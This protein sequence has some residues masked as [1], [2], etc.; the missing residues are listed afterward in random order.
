MNTHFLK[1]KDRNVKQFLLEVSTSGRGGGMER[2][3]KSEYGR[4]S[5]A[6]MKIEH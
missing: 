2:L 6:C 5:H 1:M 4:Y 3:L